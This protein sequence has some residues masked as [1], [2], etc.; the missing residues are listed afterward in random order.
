V[1]AAGESAAPCLPQY[2][3]AMGLSH[4]IDLR[5]APAVETLDALLA[6]EANHGAFDFAFIDAVRRAA[7]MNELLWL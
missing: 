3:S 5:I 2:A 6:D 4:K 7:G 1:A